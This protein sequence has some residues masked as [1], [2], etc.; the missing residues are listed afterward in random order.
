MSKILPHPLDCAG[1]KVAVLGAGRTGIAVSRFLAARGAHVLLSEKEK[2]PSVSRT[3]PQFIETEFGGHSRRI[4]Q[5]ELIIKS[6]GISYQMPLLK[7]ARLM[8]I[9]VWDELELVS[10]F[11]DSP[12]V[13][14]ITGTNGKTT[15]TSVVS[16][17]CNQAGLKTITA[18][19]IGIPI[20]SL[21][22]RLAN[23]EV[24]VLELSS[25]QL[26]TQESFRPHIAA[27]LNLTPDHLARHVSMKTYRKA[28]EKIFKNQLRRDFCVL[29]YEDSFCRKMAGSCP[30]NVLFFSSKRRLR[31]GIWYDARGW[32]FKFSGKEFIIHPR[33]TLPGMHNIENALAA[34]GITALFGIPHTDIQKALASFKG[35]PHRLEFIGCIRGITYINDSKSTNVHS[36][37]VALNS[38]NG[39]VW[40]ILGGEDKGSSYNLL[41]KLVK[42]H[43]AGVLLIGE[44]A[45]TIRKEL[46][47]SAPC[48]MCGTMK[49]AVRY[50]AEH[51]G[52]GDTVVLSPACASFDQYKNFEDRGEDFKRLVHALKKD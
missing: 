18:G 35:V 20:S 32:H 36:A 31:A 24:I 11:L 14:G 28:K 39:P 29:N 34:A 45:H 16:A 7:K 12:K 51:A 23:A 22:D 44:A 10:C 6:P 50:C 49:K 9:P 3:I 38:F 46:G 25:Y 40:L 15:T 37:A 19:N 1:K 30:G 42:D 43:A 13:I 21:L 52:Q 27:V 48:I 33:W 26:E 41:R 5:T 2:H 8:K 17:I 47:G 4:L